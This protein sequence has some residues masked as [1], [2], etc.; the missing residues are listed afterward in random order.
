MDPSRPAAPTAEPGKL[1]S[2][3]PAVAEAWES[4]AEGTGAVPFARP[5]WVAAWAAAAGAEVTPLVLRPGDHLTG[6]LPLVRRRGGTLATPTD[7]HTPVFAAVAASGT[8]LDDLVS[9]LARLGSPGIRVD[10]VD[11]AGATC[12][13]L[14]KG[15]REAGYRVDLRPRMWSPYI[16]LTMGWEAYE[17]TLTAKK[18]SD[19]RRRQRRL[20]ERGRVAVDV[21]DGRTDL[22]GLLAEGFAVEGAGWKG[23]AGTAIASSARTRRLYTEAARWA[24]QRGWLRLA[25]LRVGGRAIAFDYCLQVDGFHYLLKTGYDP[26]FASFA[27]GNLLR[28]EMIRNA[29]AEALQ[30]YEFAGAEEPWKQEWTATTREIVVLEAWAPTAAGRALASVAASQRV[31]RRMRRRLAGA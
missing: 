28:R 13:A 9:E 6:L 15:L 23:R 3:D 8:D 10:F 20:S 18:R 14:I 27:P 7:W 24:A 19:M 26:G 2:L 12:A 31:M 17:G 25:F 22:E 11:R 30:A 29:F 5:G 1:V 4:L 16:D 21:H